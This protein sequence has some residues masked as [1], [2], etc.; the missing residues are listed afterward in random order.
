MGTLIVSMI[1]AGIVIAI[2]VTLI[3]RHKAGKTS[4]GCDCT[5]CSGCK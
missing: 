5:N 4:C 1:L 3:K 2:I